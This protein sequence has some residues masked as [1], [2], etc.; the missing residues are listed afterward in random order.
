MVQVNMHIG[1][2]HNIFILQLSGGI[3]LN[4][5]PWKC[6]VGLNAFVISLSCIISEILHKLIFFDNGGG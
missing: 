3:Y 4:P 5:W 1:N 6:G 2:V